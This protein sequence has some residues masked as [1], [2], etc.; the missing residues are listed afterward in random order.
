MD[1]S[2]VAE[3]NFHLCKAEQQRQ[4][5]GKLNYLTLPAHQ[6]IRDIPQLSTA[7]KGSRGKH[8]KKKNSSPKA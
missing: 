2:T 8:I 3:Q 1:A 5:R 4:Q 7:Q 6:E